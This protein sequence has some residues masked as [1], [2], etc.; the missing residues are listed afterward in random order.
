MRYR[1]LNVYDLDPREVGE[2][3]VVVMGYMLQLLRDPLRGLAAVR[4]VCR[5]HLVL[6]DTVS[7]PLSLIPSPVARLDARR[8]GR[9]CFVFNRRGL[10]RAVRL[11]GFEIEAVT[12]IVRDRYAPRR[13]GDRV[14]LGAQAMCA[15]GLRGRS[16]ALRAR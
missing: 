2:F 11:A 9:E 12:P 1:D 6:L 7:R 15:L 8:D 4:G 5:G 10:A 3:D 14:R 13:P 16:V